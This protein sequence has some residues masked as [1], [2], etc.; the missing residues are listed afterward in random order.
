MLKPEPSAYHKGRTAVLHPRD[1]G[2]CRLRPSSTQRHFTNVNL[3]NTI[4]GPFAISNEGPV[5]F[6]FS[7]PF[8]FVILPSISAVDS[9][10]RCSALPLSLATPSSFLLPV[11][12]PGFSVSAAPSSIDCELSAAAPC[13]LLPRRR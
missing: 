13:R 11:F 2:S 9:F 7:L 10:L 4:Y 12:T 1:V 3:T 6:S 8:V 5:P